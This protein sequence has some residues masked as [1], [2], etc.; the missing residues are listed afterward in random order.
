MMYL[1]FLEMIREECRH[2]GV[3]DTVSS[4]A[5]FLSK[6][7]R[8]LNLDRTLTHRDHILAYF[9]RWEL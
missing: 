9:G 5:G 1:G 7:S 6:W 3:A 4:R 2:V 8:F